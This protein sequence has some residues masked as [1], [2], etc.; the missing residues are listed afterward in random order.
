MAKRSKKRPKTG[1]RFQSDH[2]TIEPA[3]NME[4]RVKT[5]VNQNE[6]TGSLGATEQYNR[7]AT[8]EVVTEAIEN[9]KK[10][11]VRAHE[12]W[13]GVVDLNKKFG[14]VIIQKKK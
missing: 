3:P 11:V 14:N 13:H 2:I 8:Q 6:M 7:K 9:I 10:K 1:V 12:N 4:E 5:A